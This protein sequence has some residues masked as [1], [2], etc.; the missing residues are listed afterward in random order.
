MPLSVLRGWVAAAVDTKG[1][2]LVFDDRPQAYIV[3]DSVFG[4]IRGNRC[5][6]ALSSLHSLTLQR[7]DATATAFFALGVAGLLVFGF[8][9][10]IGASFG[11]LD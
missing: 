3:G 2:V 4:A 10:L 9:V 7:I 11:G 5:A 1:A 8:Y 6:L